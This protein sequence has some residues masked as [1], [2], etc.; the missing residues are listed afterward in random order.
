MLYLCMI[1]VRD[2]TI[3][4]C[5]REHNNAIFMHDSDGGLGL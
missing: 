4:L 1:T 3:L 2:L 5:L